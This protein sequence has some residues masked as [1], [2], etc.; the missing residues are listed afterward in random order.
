V[1]DKNV[2]VPGDRPVWKTTEM[3]ANLAKQTGM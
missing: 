2:E 1:T 3:S